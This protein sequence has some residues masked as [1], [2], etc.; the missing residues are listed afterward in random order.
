MATNSANLPNYTCL[1]T[2]ERSV[3]RI[4][5]AKSLF[6]DRIHVEVAFIE[7]NEMFSWPGAH[8]FE[9]YLLEQIPQVGASGAGAFGGWTRA[10]FGAAGPDFM[11]A[12]ACSVEGR[13]GSQYRFLM[14][15]RTSDYEVRFGGKKTI[16]PYTGFVCV[17]PDSLEVMFL[18]VSV[19]Q[20]PSPIA[21]ISE[22]I[23]FARARVGLADFLLPQNDELTI[24]D[25]EGTENRN[26]IE[27][28]G[29]R[30]YTS[31]SSISFDAEPK[32]A[33][34]TKASSEDLQ[35]PGGIPL[36][37]KLESPIVSDDSA[38]G[39]PIMARLNRT[40]NSVGISIPKGAVVSG[41]I[42]GLEQYLEPEKYFL[43]TF[44]FSSVSFGGK[45]VMFRAGLIGPRLQVARRL[46]STAG[47]R[48]PGISAQRST[49]SESGLEIEGS[50][51]SF[52][53]FRVRGGSLRLSR[54]L[55]MIYETQSE[56]P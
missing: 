30:E 49:R 18:E 46:A 53:T 19:G 7:G 10:L 6:H 37:L 42:R 20:L 40:V 27:F 24:A 56:K 22:S 3:R 31:Q 25:R 50:P 33:T 12:G 51:S 5:K 41:R 39:D 52:G 14:P 45:R 11:N 32:A 48:N 2:I 8:T 28:T 38:V 21:S 35:L 9:P 13:R 54:G 55:H 47:G 23:H 44:E 43:V 4:D 17:D 34:D 29:C 1:E 36:D 15:A 16:A 26:V